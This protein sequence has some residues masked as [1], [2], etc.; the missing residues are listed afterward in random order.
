MSEPN[1][2][3]RDLASPRWMIAKAVL[4]IAVFAI[5]G[6]LLV[7]RAIEA[8]AGE[9]IHSA[10]AG[11]WVIGL[12]GLGAWSACRAYY[13]GFYVITSYCDPTYRY[14]GVWSAMRWAIRRTTRR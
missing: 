7:V 8:H 2:L 6:V 3:S 14:A 13:F 12:Y 4:F 9:P 5:C 11:L 1:W 10:T